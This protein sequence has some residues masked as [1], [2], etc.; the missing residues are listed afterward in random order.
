MINHLADALYNIGWGS[1]REESTPLSPEQCR[2]LRE[3][4][5][6]LEARVPRVEGEVGG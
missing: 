4:I 2:A 1:E 6:D 5:A 3:Y